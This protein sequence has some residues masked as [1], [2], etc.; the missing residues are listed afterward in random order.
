MV[1]L[2][3]VT[4]LS[5]D[6]RRDVLEFLE[7][8]HDLD[9]A[10]LNDHLRLDLA[11]GPR[12]G[13]VAVLAHDDDSQLAGYAQASTGNEGFVVDGFVWSS[14]EGDIDAAQ[15]ELMRALLAALPTDHAV[16]WWAHADPATIE[17]ARVLGMVPD[18]QLLRMHRPLPTPDTTDAPVR[19]FTAM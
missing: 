2:R 8:A 4:S 16:T 15:F 9:C 17:S 19:P 3:T 1:R 14:F 7:A 18:R 13:F 6:E 12:P 10:R 5:P 11:Q